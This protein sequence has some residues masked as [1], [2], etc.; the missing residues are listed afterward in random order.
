MEDG[1]AVSYLKD[2]SWTPERY[3]SG[4]DIKFPHLSAD[5]A[6]THNY[7]NSTLW[8]RDAAYLRLKNVEIGY[9]LP[10]HIMRKIGLQSTRIY[11]NG[12]NLATWSGLFPGEDPEIPTYSDSDYEPYPIMKTVNFGL[13]LSF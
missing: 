7:Q 2:Y 10:A 5:A 3:E 1:S 9:T 12:T 13:S 11:I 8:I 4:A 6:Q